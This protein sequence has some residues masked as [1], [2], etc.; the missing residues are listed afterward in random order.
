M[1]IPGYVTDGI[2]FFIVYPRVSN[3]GWNVSVAM[4]C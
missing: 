1:L 4:G 2:G 3:H